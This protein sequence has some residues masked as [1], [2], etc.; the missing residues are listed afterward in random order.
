MGSAPSLI[1]NRPHLFTEAFVPI[2]LVDARPVAA[3]LLIGTGAAVVRVLRAV[4]AVVVGRAVTPVGPRQVLAS[5]SVLR[6]T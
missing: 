2:A 4:D 6:W 3:Q 1:I 5:G